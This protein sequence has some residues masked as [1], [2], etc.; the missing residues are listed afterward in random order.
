MIALDNFGGNSVNIVNFDQEIFEKYSG[1]VIP[2][3]KL[4]NHINDF[5]NNKTYLEPIKVHEIN[6]LQNADNIN[7]FNNGSFKNVELY[8]NE[9]FKA[10]NMFNNAYV[11]NLYIKGGTLS[12]IGYNITF[13]N[14][15]I[16]CDEMQD[17]F[18][19]IFINNTSK[20]EGLISI[21]C[22]GKIIDCFDMCLTKFASVVVNCGWLSSAFNDAE[23]IDCG[24]V[25]LNASYAYRVGLN[26]LQSVVEEERLRYKILLN[27]HEGSNIFNSATIDN[28]NFA[29]NN[30]DQALNSMSFY[31]LNLTIS[32]SC[33]SVGNY[34][35]APGYNNTLNNTLFLRWNAD[36]N[37]HKNCFNK[38]YCQNLIAYCGSPV[39]GQTCFNSAT[40]V[41]G[42]VAIPWGNS[43]AVTK[44]S[45]FINLSYEKL[46]S[47][48]HMF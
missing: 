32:G 19:N 14:L 11:E 4:C 10:Q 31:N 17:C 33:S 8:L 28:G 43:L 3:N 48:T 40:C 26:F 44:Q 18:K 25:L 24:N 5:M 37:F 47:N 2:S 46:I 9:N 30:M 1:D 20:R 21:N 29:F 13:K 41:S 6:P 38:I 27:F 42:L 45:C 23:L 39:A 15:V 35:T 36:Y 34:T 7:A 12:N 22:K 16:D